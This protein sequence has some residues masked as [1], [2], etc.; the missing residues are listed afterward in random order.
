[1]PKANFPFGPVRVE[2]SR[3]SLNRRQF[4][5]TT[6]LAAS[7]LTASS[8]AAPR[9]KLKSP[10]EKLD[11][12]AIGAGGKG[13]DDARN[14]A[15]E[16]IVAICDVDANVLAAAAKTWPKARQYRDYRVMLEKEKSLD[17]VTIGIPD[18]HHAPAAMLAIKSGRHVY[19]QKP[20][21]HTISEAR[22]H[23][24]DVAYK[25]HPR[26]GYIGLQD[27]GSP[28]WFKNI[29]LRPLGP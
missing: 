18:H 5:Y 26:T 1:M 11:I 21:T 27:H 9:A 4:I 12:G 22:A 29:K 15:S 8:Y 3:H 17:A 24:L 13:G 19:C 20:L 23:K 16:N 28:C 2:L 7:A 14:C 25:D 10:N 6:T